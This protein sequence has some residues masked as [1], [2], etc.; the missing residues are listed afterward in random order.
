MTYYTLSVTSSKYIAFQLRI[1]LRSPVGASAV[2]SAGVFGFPCFVCH[3]DDI[4]ENGYGVVGLPA[5]RGWGCTHSRKDP[6]GLG[7]SVPIV[8][9]RKTVPIP[10]TMG[11]WYAV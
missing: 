1:S 5:S 4:R 3:S 8:L 2:L 7:T 11:R 10:A 6:R 9:G